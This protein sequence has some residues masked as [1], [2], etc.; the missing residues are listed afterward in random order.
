MATSPSRSSVYSELTRG[1]VI[2][3]ESPSHGI[4]AVLSGKLRGGIVG[5]EETLVLGRDLSISD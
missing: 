3:S 4:H 2:L 5:E 1:I